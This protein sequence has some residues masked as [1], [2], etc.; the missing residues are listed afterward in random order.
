MESRNCGLP[1]WG[2]D[3][4]YFL[5]EAER[6]LLRWCVLD[7]Q[8]QNLVQDLW[9]PRTT[10]EDVGALYERLD[11]MG[12]ADLIDAFNSM[13]DRT[14]DGA[15]CWWFVSESVRPEVRGLLSPR[16]RP[17]S[18]PDD[19]DAALVDRVAH[20]LHSNGAFALLNDGPDGFMPERAWAIERMLAREAL[21]AITG[22]G[23]GGRSCG[24][25]ASAPVDPRLVFPE[26]DEDE[27]RGS[28]AESLRFVL[29]GVS[30]VDGEG[31]GV[32]GG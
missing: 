19:G 18:M 5:N 22:S 7:D 12:D 6:S 8:G 3:G 4:R 17:G 26:I 30:A 13:V 24:V 27:R 31:K 10:R 15:D 21:A 16:I 1:C 23:E 25:M 9:E 28:L 11:S 2:R 14:S 20:A 29:E 32:V